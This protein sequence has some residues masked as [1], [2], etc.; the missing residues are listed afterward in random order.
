MLYRCYSGFGRCLSNSSVIT[1][2][3]WYTISM[4]GVEALDLEAR[5]PNA[6]VLEAPA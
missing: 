2:L 4:Y 5:V 3:T 1:L 6:A